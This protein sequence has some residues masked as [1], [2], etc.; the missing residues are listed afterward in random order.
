MQIYNMEAQWRYAF[1]PGVSVIWDINQ[2]AFDTFALVSLTKTRKG[3]SAGSGAGG[4]SGVVSV[5]G[6][7][8][9][10]QYPPAAFSYQMKHI[11]IGVVSEG[12][13]AQCMISLLRDHT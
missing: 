13:Y 2:P 8:L 6:D 1:G 12:Q 7:D 9:G 10:G 11:Q 5:D 3:N 4:F